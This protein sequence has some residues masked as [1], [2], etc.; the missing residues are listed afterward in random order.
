VAD[1]RTIEVAVET[2]TKYVGCGDNSCRFRKPRGM[3]T[4]GG[5]RCADRPLVMSALARL[6]K[7][8]L[9]NIKR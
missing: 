2:C 6:Y 1:D 3:G 9:A 8:A 7:A 4:N 5:C